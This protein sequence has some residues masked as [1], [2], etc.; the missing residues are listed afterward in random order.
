ML[1]KAECKLVAD[2]SDEWQGPNTWGL[3]DGQ[4]L[5]LLEV[6]DLPGFG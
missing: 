6:L 3:V 2:R 1:N 5:T 4:R